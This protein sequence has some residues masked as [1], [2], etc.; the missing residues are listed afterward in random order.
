MSS[1]PEQAEAEKLVTAIRRHLPWGGREGCPEVWH[2]SPKDA[3]DAISQALLSRRASEGCVIDDKGVARKVL[4]PTQGP[5]IH[6]TKDGAIVPDGSCFVW[7]FET[8]NK[9]DGFTGK[10]VH[11]RYSTWFDKRWDDCSPP[12]WNRRA[13]DGEWACYSTEAAATAATAAQEKKP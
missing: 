9:F 8:I 13:P 6:M 12:C 4:S 2:L 3:I 11:M 5:M 10:L 1:T 7:A